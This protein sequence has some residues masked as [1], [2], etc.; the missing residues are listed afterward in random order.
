MPLPQ[1]PHCRYARHRLALL[2]PLLLLLIS[3]SL[4]LRPAPAAAQGTLSCVNKTTANGVGYANYGIFAS[5]STI[6]AG[7]A[8]VGGP[9]TDKLSISTNGGATFANKTTADGL[10]DNTV[11]GVTVDGGI[12]YVATAGGL[13]ISTNSGASFTNKT[14]TNGL[15]NNAV[16]GVYANGS[17][18]YVGTSG[19]VSISTDGGA[20]F[21]S[22]TITNGLGTIWVTSVYASGSTV[23]AA[24]GGGVSICTMPTSAAPEINVQGNGVSIASGDSTPSTA[25]HTAFGSVTVGETLTR[26]F[27]IS[28]SGTAALTG[29]SVTVADGSSCAAA[30]NT[31]CATAAPF[32]VSSAPAAT[33][34]AGSSSSFTVAFAPTAAGLVETVVTIASND[35]DEN[36]YTFAISGEGMEPPPQATITIVLDARPDLPTNHG[37][38]GSLGAFLL[39]DPA[40]DDGDAYTKTRT[41]TVTP[42]TYTVRRNNPDSWFTTAIACTPA[43]NAAIDLPQRRAAI[44]VADGANVTCTYTVDRAVT[45][46]ARAFNDLVRRTTNLGKRN[47]GDPWQTGQPM[48]LTTSPT[49]TLGSGVTAPVGS[50]SASASPTYAP[51]ATPSAQPSRSAGRSPPPLPLTQLMGNL[52]E[53]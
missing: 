30:V 8:P 39:D 25:D 53:R 24:T 41:F 44:T 43:S 37:F 52:A 4:L 28:N 23:Y 13:S 42:G 31:V 10:G 50:T 3:S 14:T 29:V 38:G 36:P 15:G 19:G 32:S 1:Q 17:T 45:I 40:V 16:W 27:T 26:T 2:I 7:S 46:H 11:R 12:V 47:P 6:Y 18:V 49:Q 9:T 48:T 5:G 51:A 22:Y 20:T 34:A 21:T 33:I 35:S